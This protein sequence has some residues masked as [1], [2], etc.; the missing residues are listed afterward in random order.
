MVN[1]HDYLTQLKY[2]V[3]AVVDEDGKPW[4]VPVTVKKY[5]HGS[6]E[7]FSKADAVHSKAI[8][9]SPNIAITAFT[10]K[11]DE[12]G[13]YGFYAHAQA[14]KTLSLPMDAVLY[15]AQVTEA[16]YNDARHIKTPIHKKD[17]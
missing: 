15:R 13:E 17:L 3:I 7:W 8:A 16:W 10:T 9:R 11:Q 12:R 14:R 4:A 5:H 1:V 6:F 2:I